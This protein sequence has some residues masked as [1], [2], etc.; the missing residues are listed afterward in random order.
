MVGALVAVL[1]LAFQWYYGLIPPNH[2]WHAVKSVGWPYLA[3]FLI[4]ALVSAIRTPV[5]LEREQAATVAHLR[6]EIL[7]GLPV[8]TTNALRYLFERQSFAQGVFSPS[9]PG[10][11]AK[12]FDDIYFK[13]EQRGIVLG[14]RNRAGEV[15]YTIS[16]AMRIILKYVLF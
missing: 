13:C 6:E 15:V 16:P 10:I 7:A 14:S 4:L 11:D 2:N 12:A 1:I 5:R 3:L 8:Q 9:P